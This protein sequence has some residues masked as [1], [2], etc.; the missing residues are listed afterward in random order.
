MLMS[1]RRLLIGAG[2]AAL[3]LSGSTIY[4][5]KVRLEK[6]KMELVDTKSDLGKIRTAIALTESLRKDNAKLTKE[7]DD[8]RRELKNARGYSDPLPPDIRGIIDRM[9]F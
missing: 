2:L 1:L 5:Q 3:I 7:R 9:R 6:I 4:I 8:L